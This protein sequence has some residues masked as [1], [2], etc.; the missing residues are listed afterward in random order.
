MKF[1][2]DPKPDFTPDEERVLI[3]LMVPLLAGQEAFTADGMTAAFAA[4]NQIRGDL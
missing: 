2:E 1:I 4:F 3:A